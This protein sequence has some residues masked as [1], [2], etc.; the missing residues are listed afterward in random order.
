MTK[1]YECD[2]CGV[3]TSLREQVCSPRQLENMGAYCDT[4]MPA[5]KM[6]SDMKERLAYVCGGCGRPAEQADMVCDPLPSG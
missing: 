4:T 3:V 2:T 1:I 5:D 6:C